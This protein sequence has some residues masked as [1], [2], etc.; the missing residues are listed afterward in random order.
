[1]MATANYVTNGSQKKYQ[2][3]LEDIVKLQLTNPKP[4]NSELVNLG[5]QPADFPG[6]SDLVRRSRIHFLLITVFVAIRSH[7]TYHLLHILGAH[8]Q[9]NFYLVPLPLLIVYFNSNQDE[10]LDN[11]SLGNCHGYFLE[12]TANFIVLYTS[13]TILIF[14]LI[15]II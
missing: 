14:K 9:N 3:H 11:V 8:N 10:C 2:K 15:A 12:I 5:R 6:D 1:M 7:R 13:S 4:P